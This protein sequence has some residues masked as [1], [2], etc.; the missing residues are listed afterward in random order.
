MHVISGSAVEFACCSKF[1]TTCKAT[2]IDRESTSFSVSLQ[3][4]ASAWT[5]VQM[6]TTCMDGSQYAAE[7]SGF[8][9]TLAYAVKPAY[10]A[11]R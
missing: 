3:P 4:A 9:A 11:L 1:D 6:A 8:A 7:H 2:V 10:E 5:A